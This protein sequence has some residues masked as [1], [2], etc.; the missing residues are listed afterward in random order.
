MAPKPSDV[1]MAD[2]H[3][4]ALW[5]IQGNS[6]TSV[7]EAGILAF[8]AP[9]RGRVPRYSTGIEIGWPNRCC[10]HAPLAGDLIGIKNWSR[11]W[12]DGSRLLVAYVRTPQYIFAFGGIIPDSSPI[13]G[14]YVEPVT[15]LGRSNRGVHVSIFK[16]IEGETDGDFLAR[17]GSGGLVWRVDREPPLGLRNP[18]RFLEV[19]ASRLGEEE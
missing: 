1:P 14:I 6:N 16:P 7:A 17:M 8:G 19:A 18:R 2:P 12:R 13:P 11:D 10:I 4:D 15:S 3:P 9:R 5:P